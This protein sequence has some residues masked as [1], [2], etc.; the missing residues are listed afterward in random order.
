MIVDASTPSCLQTRCAV[1]SARVAGELRMVSGINC[2]LASQRPICL[3]ARRPRFFRGREKSSISTDQ[4]DL[5]WR[6]NKSSWVIN[7][8]SMEAD[9]ATPA[10]GLTI[11]VNVYN[12]IKS[13]VKKHLKCRLHNIFW[14][15]CRCYYVLSD[16]IDLSMLINDS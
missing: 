2:C 1:A 7:R 4:S 5:A 14:R 9:G 6:N 8:L 15:A 13:R 16:V 12:F 11:P 3:A 10:D